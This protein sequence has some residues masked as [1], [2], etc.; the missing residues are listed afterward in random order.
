MS[1]NNSKRT[2]V[3]QHALKRLH[4]VEKEHRKEYVKRPQPFS[5]QKVIMVILLIIVLGTMMV[6]LL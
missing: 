6:S 3:E 5:W 2:L 1:K 4:E